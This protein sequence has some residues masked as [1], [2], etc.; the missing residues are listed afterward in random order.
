MG[1]YLWQQFALFELLHTII[2]YP[3]R[4]PLYRLVV[5]T[6]MLAVAVQLYRTMGVVEPLGMGYGV[7][8]QIGL[9]FGFIAYVLCT[10][11]SFP[12]HW[13]R[14]RDQVR[15]RADHTDDRPSNFS[16]TKKLGWMFDISHNVRMVG[17]VQEPRDSLPPPPPPSLRKFIRGAFIRL[18]LSAALQDLLTIA[19]SQNPV[20]DPRVHDPTDGPETYLAAVPL[21]RRIPYT[22]V[23]AL[24]IITPFNISHNAEGLVLVGLG[25]WSPTLWPGL[26]GRWGDAYTLRKFWGYVHR[27]TCLY[28]D[29]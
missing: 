26:W 18:I 13:R 2:L 14:V 5:L 17:W 24:L 23:V 28:P 3:T 8:F 22:L 29:R 16:F 10:E 15:A 21:L 7:G 12:D 1:E 11:G 9:H 6:A 25:F 27:A 19:V 20:F 4:Q